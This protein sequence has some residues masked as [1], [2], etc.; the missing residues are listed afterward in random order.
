[1]RWHENSDR[2]SRPSD[3]RRAPGRRGSLSWGYAAA[4]VL[5]G[6]AAPT[7]ALLI[8]IL[9]GHA[10]GED[11]RVHAFFYL[12]ELIGTSAV[13]GLAGYLAGRRAERLRRGRDRYQ[14]LAEK[15]ELTGL[16]NARAFRGHYRR[17]IEHAARFHEPVSLL[18]IDVD[19]LKSINDELGHTLGNLALRH[20]ARILQTSKRGLDVAVR[21][22]GDEF[23][24]LMPGADAAGAERLAAAILDRARSQ[25]LRRTKLPR[26]VTVTIGIASAIPSS[27]SFDLL[28]CADRALY[29]GKR[30]GKDR[31]LLADRE[32]DS[33]PNTSADAPQKGGGRPLAEFS[34]DDDA[35]GRRA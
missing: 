18:M 5:L 2:V 23:A 15:D 14:L 29:E 16:L 10:P 35:T 33:F 31:S 1:M 20:L 27:P 22:G 30:A 21:W 12:Y 11:L 3:E 13:F 6:A 19:D 24:V 34:D 7:A 8:R 9:T 4:G 28:Q 26:P 32:S 17:A 25:P